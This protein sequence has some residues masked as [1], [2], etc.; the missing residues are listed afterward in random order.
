LRASLVVFLSGL[1]LA[2]VGFSSASAVTPPTTTV[3][4]DEPIEGGG[5]VDA[6]EILLEPTR[7][8]LI[9]HMPFAGKHPYPDIV[10]A[11]LGNKAGL[12]GVANL[13]RL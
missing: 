1:S 2:V 9:R 12:V 13:A 10:P 4:V 3:P 5:V 7:Q 6:G 8:S 11:E